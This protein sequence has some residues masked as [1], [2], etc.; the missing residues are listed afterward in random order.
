MYRCISDHDMRSQVNSDLTV[1]HNHVFFLTTGRIHS[2]QKNKFM[3]LLVT[4]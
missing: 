2:K 4:I 1:H 3:C